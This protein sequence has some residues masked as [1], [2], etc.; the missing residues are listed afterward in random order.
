VEIALYLSDDLSPYID[1]VKEGLSYESSI[2]SNVLELAQLLNSLNELNK[3]IRESASE[4]KHDAII[5]GLF[6]F[7]CLHVDKAER[8]IEFTLN[9]HF[10]SP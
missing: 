2:F 6:N 10:C 7:I 1:A 4:F 8:N 3:I 9:T 5:C